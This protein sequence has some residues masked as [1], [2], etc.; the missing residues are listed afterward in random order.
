MVR[1]SNPTPLAWHRACDMYPAL[2]RQCG[3]FPFWSKEMPFPIDMWSPVHD[4]CS[5][6]RP[7]VS[8]IV[9]MLSQS[10]RIFPY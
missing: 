9:E 6:D 2:E 4:I 7:M 5:G 8:L 1:F 10:E 3:T